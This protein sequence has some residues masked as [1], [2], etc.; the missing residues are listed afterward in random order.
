M[1]RVT[2][3]GRTLNTRTRDMFEA[4]EYLT[5]LQLTIT[6]GSY[7]AGGVAAS[8]GT[9]DGG[10][11]IDIR[12][13]NLTT[14]QRK[15]VVL[16]ARQVGFAG[17]LRTPSQGNWPYHI[18]CIAIGDGDLSRGAANQ[19]DQYK[20]GRNGLASAGP[21][22]GPDGYRN[23][24]WEDWA[25]AHPDWRGLTV[26]QVDELKDFIRAEIKSSEA[27][28][29][30]NIYAGPRYAALQNT[31][32]AQ[33]KG[34]EALAKLVQEMDAEADARDLK[35]NGRYAF[36]AEKLNDVLAESKEDDPENPVT[37]AN[38]APKA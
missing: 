34:L 32:N 28:V 30:A 24:K 17:W 35:G 23:V 22:D 12:A 33:G 14:A 15:A 21:D 3:Q 10:G 18:H 20:R 26:G 9:H 4:V 36:F 6:Q 8:A 27:R 19:V 11:A 16:A 5:G 2:Y 1:Q 38:P 25:A 7:N 37:V 13:V 31:L 29:L